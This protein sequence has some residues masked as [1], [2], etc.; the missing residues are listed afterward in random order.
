MRFSFSRSSTAVHNVS[1]TMR[2]SGTST[3]I[4]S[5]SGRG[6]LTFLPVS[7]LR[8]FFVRFHTW[9]PRY[10]SLRSISKIDDVHHAR[11]VRFRD[12]MGDM[13]PSPLR[14]FAIVV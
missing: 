6:R 5:D 11:P 10:R 13:T 7:G 9:T 4:H 1:G 8:S 14:A 3:R 2:Q 12:G